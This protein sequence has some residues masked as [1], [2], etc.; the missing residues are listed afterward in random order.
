MLS[1]GK[2]AGG[3]GSI[4]PTSDHHLG[5]TSNILGK[6][7]GRNKPCLKSKNFGVTFTSDKCKRDSVNRHRTDSAPLGQ[8]QNGWEMTPTEHRRWAHKV[9]W[10]WSYICHIRLFINLEANSHS[11]IRASFSYII[12]SGIK[13]Y[14][15]HTR[16]IIYRSP[17]D[18]CWIAVDCLTY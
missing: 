17:W 3:T 2:A 16:H 9:L 15:R 13:M 7:E 1:L 6:R 10:N 11:H 4:L 12:T 8:R 5:C 14:R 18:Q